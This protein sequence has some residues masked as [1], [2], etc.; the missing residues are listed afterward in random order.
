ML[1]LGEYKSLLSSS[2]ASVKAAASNSR[3]ATKAAASAFAASCAASRLAR[4]KLS[5]ILTPISL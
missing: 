5:S 2:F 3:D 4:A 1:A